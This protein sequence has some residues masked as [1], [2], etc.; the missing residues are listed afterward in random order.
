MRARTTTFI[1]LSLFGAPL[2]YWLS[3]FHDVATPGAENIRFDEPEQRHEAQPSDKE[4]YEIASRFP[5]PLPDFAGGEVLA[6]IAPHHLLAADLI[7]RY[8]AGFASSSLASEYVDLVILIGP[9][10]FQVGD[11]LFLSSDR[12]WD[13]PYGVLAADLDALD[14]LYLSEENLEILPEAFGREHAINSHAAFIKRSFPRARFLPLIIANHASA[15]STDALLDKIIGLKD[16]RRLLLLGSAD[17]S[18]YKDAATAQADDKNSLA[19][20][21]DKEWDEIKT[22]AVDSPATVYLLMRYADRLGARW[23]SYENSNS[24]LLS[25]REGLDSTTSY[26][27]GYFLSEP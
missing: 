8:Y 26:I 14:E 1:F 24:A 12:D 19:I 3:T 20:I 16:E 13:T 17:F 4:F 22:M 23:Q 25:G 10:H 5:R 15:S 27:T 7:A 6:G 18:H 9:N 21:G 2:A 11:D